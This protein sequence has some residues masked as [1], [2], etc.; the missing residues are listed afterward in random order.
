MLHAPETCL[1]HPRSECLLPC[2]ASGHT[3]R[4]RAAPLASGKVRSEAGKDKTDLTAS[5][6]SSDPRP[7]VTAA[8]CPGVPPQPGTHTRS[9]GHCEPHP[10]T[11]YTEG[12]NELAFHLHHIDRDLL[13][14]H[15]ENFKVRDNT[16]LKKRAVSTWRPPICPAAHLQDA[17]STGKAITLCATPCYAPIRRSGRGN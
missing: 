2:S 7:Q 16:L 11:L 17:I 3:G 15:S 4:K 5:L 14:P 8:A 10:R 12:S 1:P 6:W 13:F 9:P